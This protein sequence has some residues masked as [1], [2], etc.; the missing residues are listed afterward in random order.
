MSLFDK[1]LGREK[2]PPPPPEQAVI[3]SFQYG[4][5]DL[6]RLF[7]LED[8]LERAILAASAG[9]LD[10]NEMAVDGSHGS[11]YMYGPDADVLFRAVRPILE[12]ADFMRGARVQIR[13][14]PAGPDTPA[15]EVTL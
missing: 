12:A 3:V 1:L 11:L 10:G 8:R 13:Y 5:T 4:S 6:S 2:A 7:Q 14:G 15:S 9:E